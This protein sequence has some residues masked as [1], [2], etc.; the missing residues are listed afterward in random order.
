MS[1]RACQG[2]TVS[3]HRIGF[4]GVH[5]LE[6]DAEAVEQYDPSRIGVN[7]ARASVGSDE[8]FSSYVKGLV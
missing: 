7:D 6:H 4:G 3:L 1:A 2:I 8:R 5:A